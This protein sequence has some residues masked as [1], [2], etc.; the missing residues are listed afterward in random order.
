MGK[1]T[2][3]FSSNSSLVFS[4]ASSPL[5][6]TRA[7]RVY[8]GAHTARRNT[9]V[10]VAAIFARPQVADPVGVNRAFAL[11]FLRRPSRQSTTTSG[12]AGTVPPLGVEPSDAAAADTASDSS[13]TSGRSSSVLVATTAV[14]SAVLTVKVYM[15]S[16]L[17]F[18]L[19]VGPMFGLFTPPFVKAFAVAVTAG[20]L[21]SA[22]TWTTTVAMTAM[23][24]WTALSSTGTY[25]VMTAAKAAT[26]VWTAFY[27]SPDAGFFL[28]FAL[29]AIG[30]AIIL[31][32][33]TPPPIALVKTVKAKGAASNVPTS[34]VVPASATG[35]CKAGKSPDQTLVASLLTREIE[36]RLKLEA[37]VAALTKKF[38]QLHDKCE[39]LETSRETVVR[40]HKEEAAACA[41]A[42]GIILHLSHNP[43]T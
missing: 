27:W 40:L 37:Y 1:V 11:C 12:A 10:A 19:S 33:F 3:S 28:S 21:S 41:N 38:E 36:E 8:A 24:V 25:F 6:R 39:A 20:A 13:A 5:A 2:P 9:H 23:Q 18:L 14:E 31:S 34:S 42:A 22:G 26:R 32:Q 15:C 4:L 16:F 35:Q 7:A 17:L 29:S 30:T 43:K